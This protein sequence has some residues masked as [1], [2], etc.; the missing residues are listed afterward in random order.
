MVFGVIVIIVKREDKRRI[1]KCIYENCIVKERYKM[2][3]RKVLIS[4]RDVI[5]VGG[6]GKFFL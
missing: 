3:F 1:F 6:K 4:R 2:V 5:L